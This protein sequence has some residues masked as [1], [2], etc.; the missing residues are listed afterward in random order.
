MNGSCVACGKHGV[1]DR[2]HIR[3]RGAT[4]NKWEDHNLILLCRVHHIEQG[5][6]GWKKF[7]DKYP[8][9]FKELEMKGW[10]FIK[11]FGVV[12]LRK[13]DE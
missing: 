13:M 8:K 2:A 3:T 12:K 6:I 4:G 9:I 1:C 11:E 7:A 10:H 5:A